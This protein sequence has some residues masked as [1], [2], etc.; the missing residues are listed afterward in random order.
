MVLGTTMQLGYGPIHT[1]CTARAIRPHFALRCVM[2]PCLVLC[3]A[4]D[5]RFTTSWTARFMRRLLSATKKHIALSYHV[6]LWD[7]SDQQHQ[8]SCIYKTNGWLKRVCRRAWLF[9]NHTIPAA[10][11]NCSPKF[12]QGKIVPG[13]NLPWQTPPSCICFQVSFLPPPPP[14]LS[15]IANRHVATMSDSDLKLRELQLPILQH[16]PIAGLCL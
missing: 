14:S 2:L 7:K 12:R 9:S 11:A 8:I 6:L 10:A 5:Q 13:K 15:L 1:L 3:V 4:S 16:V